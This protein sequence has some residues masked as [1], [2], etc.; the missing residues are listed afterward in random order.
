[1]KLY[2]APASPFSRKVRIAAAL[3]GLSVELVPTETIN[4]ADPIRQKNPLGKI[5]T[6]ETDDGDC[7][8]DS[9]VI[10]A[11]L[12]DQA[13]GGRIVPRDP[14]ARTR[15]L[16]LEALADGLADAAVLVIYETRYR[17]PGERSAKW[18]AHQ[19]EKIERALARLEQAPP[20][21]E[22][23]PDIGQI[24]LACALGYLDLRFSGEWRTNHPGLVA[25][26]DDF[27][28]KIPAFA[29]TAA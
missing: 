21:L 20:A 18:V 23:E 14:K 26:L 16:V 24:A 11:W 29:A 10:A 9:A 27:A 25:W 6:L 2:F 8:F 13:G 4:P 19:G 3:L 17:E 12:D 7:I 22:G 28:Q 5:P 1:M 15:A